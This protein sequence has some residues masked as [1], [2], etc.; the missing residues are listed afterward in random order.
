ML[1]EGLPNRRSLSL[2]YQ[3]YKGRVHSFILIHIF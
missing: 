1:A 2:L 3:N